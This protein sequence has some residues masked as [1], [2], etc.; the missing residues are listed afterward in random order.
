MWVQAPPEEEPLKGWGVQYGHFFMGSQAK[1]CAAKALASKTSVQFVHA[2]NDS[3]DLKHGAR[4][5]QEVEVTILQGDGAED[6]LLQPGEGGTAREGGGVDEPP[7]AEVQAA[8]GRAAEERG[9]EA[10]LFEGPGAV[11]EDELVDALGGEVVEPAS[12]HVAVPVDGFHEP[13][14]EADEGERPGVRAEGGVDGAAHGVRAGARARARGPALGAAAG[15][16]LGVDEDKRRR[17]PEAAPARGERGG[18]GAVL[19]GEAGEDAAEEDVGEAADAIDPF[20]FFGGGGAG[21]GGGG[22]DRRLG[23]VGVE[24]AEHRVLVDVQHRRV[25]PVTHRRGRRAGRAEG[26][27]GGRPAELGRDGE[28]HALRRE[29]RRPRSRVSTRGREWLL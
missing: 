12:E 23:D 20:A 26:V 18:A 1:L 5:E 27:A 11:D 6:E 7:R 28:R 9:G 21:E 8:E 2:S 4:S 3:E 29:W 14:G 16:E 19:G 22:G 25:Q 17:P 24:E 13:A 10:Q 15:D